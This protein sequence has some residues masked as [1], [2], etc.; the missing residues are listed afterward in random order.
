M[1]AT[2]MIDPLDTR[3]S[4]LLR[5]KDHDEDAWREFWEIYQPLIWRVTKTLGLPDQEAADVVQEVV[6]SVFQAI[7]RYESRPHSHA[8]RG[9]LRTI[10]RNTTLNYLSQRLAA[11]GQGGS[12]LARF[13]EERVDPR[14]DLGLE[15]DRQHQQQLI[16]W[17]AKQVANQVSPQ[18]FAAFWRTT[19]E[20]ESVLVVADKLQMTPGNIYVARG[21]VM[22]RMRQLI[23]QRLQEEE[24]C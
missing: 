24:S 4:L 12:S 9:W 17:A 19:V 5:L 15:W 3:V 23:E 10:A 13:I 11:R 20:G 21:R 7:Q 2:P 1:N 16:A 6:M 22:L 14:A 8:F 18:T